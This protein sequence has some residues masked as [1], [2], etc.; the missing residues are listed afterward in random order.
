MTLFSMIL[1][2]VSLALPMVADSATYYV[3]KNSLGGTCND[4]NPGT[5][6]S[7]RCSITQGRKLLSGGDTLYIRAGTYVEG[8]VATGGAPPST[9]GVPDGLGTWAT[10]TKFF[11]FPGDAKPILRPSCGQYAGITDAVIYIDANWI[12]VDNLEIDTTG[13]SCGGEG[14]VGFQMF[15]NGRAHYRIS[16]CDL[17]ASGN[18]VGGTLIQGGMPFVEVLNNK[19]HDIHGYGSYWSGRDSVFE[20]NEFYNIGGYGMHMYNTGATNVS[21]NT[22]RNNYFHDNPG[23]YK[24][25]TVLVSHGSDNQVYNNLIVNNCGGLEID[26]SCVDCKYYN[27]TIYNNASAGIF[28]GDQHPETVVNPIIRNNIVY[29]N[30]SNYRNNGVTVI[31]SNNLCNATNEI[32]THT[33]N[34]SFEDAA[35]GNYRINDN[36]AAKDTGTAITAVAGQTYNNSFYGVARPQGSAWDI[37]AAER[38]QGGGQSPNGNEI[39]VKTTGDNNNDCFAAENSATPKQTLGGTLGALTCMTVPGKI[40]TLWGGTYSDQIITSST[41]ITGGGGPSYT[42]ATIIRGRV[43]DTVTWQVPVGLNLPLYMTNNDSY[44]VFRNIIFD[45]A[46]RA[47]SNGPALTT[48]VHHI[49][50]EGCE[51]KNSIFETFFVQNANNIELFQTTVHNSGSGFDALILDGN[52]SSFLCQQ[53]TVYSSGA[54]GIMVNSSGTKSNITIRES[55]TRDNTGNGI[56]IGASTGTLVQNHL[57]YSNG[58]IGLAIRTGAIGMKA[59]HNTMAVNGGNGVQCDA[60]AT[61]AEVKNTISFGNS[62]TQIVNNCTAQTS[63]NFTTDPLFVGSPTNFHLADGSGAIDTG[64]SIPSVTVDRDGAIRPQGLPDRG[65]YERTQAT[66]PNPPGPDVTV[67]RQAAWQSMMYF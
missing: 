6:T 31:A 13:T 25:A 10:A 4:T 5:A 43:G 18:T 42:N 14:G 52:V 54:A 2:V 26:H 45:S 35:G 67:S 58:G 44:I 36:S 49:R 19:F 51:M 28:I 12:H 59:Y 38:I 65:A 41:P 57:S 61:T 47:G 37:G 64:V 8:I 60:G 3:D 24:C 9:N 50:F 66:P 48:G 27:N 17:H 62:G 40:M 30:T 46:N 56:D 29:G 33:G 21:N 53:C 11:G 32:C 63:M 22:V 1:L 39:H 55:T 20:F 16:N 15:D 23:N 7:P 34:P